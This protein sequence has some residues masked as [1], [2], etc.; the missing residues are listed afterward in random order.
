VFVALLDPT[1]GSEQAGARPVI[2]VSRDAIN[3]NSSV[4][5]CVPCTN[6][7]NCK[8]IYPS[9]LLLKKGTAG[10]PLDSVAMCEQIRAVTVGRL[11]RYLGRL[12]A[13]SLRT[14]EERIK[15]ALDLE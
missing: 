3:H 15:I 2:V 6:L 12:D 5:V 8:R 10:L 7:A 9:Q 11:Q 14:L 13:S 1:K 4:I